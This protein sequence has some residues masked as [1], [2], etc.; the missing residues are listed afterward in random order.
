MYTDFMLKLPF[1]IATHS[2]VEFDWFSFNVYFLQESFAAAQILRE[3]FL[4]G[5]SMI[6]TSAPS[7]GSQF[8]EKKTSMVIGYQQFLFEHLSCSYVISHVVL[9][10]CFLIEWR[11]L[12]LCQRQCPSS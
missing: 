10:C 5:A 12:V 4:Q 9:F 3:G 8:F 11:C 6:L 1:L 7:L 2:L